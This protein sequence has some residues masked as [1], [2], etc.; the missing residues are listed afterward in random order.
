M[1]KAEYGIENRI[2][3]A[4]EMLFLRSGFAKTSMRDI[5]AYSGVG[6]GNIYNYFKNKDDIFFHLVEPV[7][8]KF[9]TLLEE[10][11]GKNFDIS[12]L[13]MMEEEY[14]EKNL[15]DYT[16]LLDGN[17][18]RMQLL[19]FKAEGSAMQNFKERYTEKATELV[20]TWFM[21]IKKSYPNI[22]VN[23]SKFSVHLHTVWMLS[24]IENIII[25]ND[26]K[27]E[28]DKLIKEYMLFETTGWRELMK[29]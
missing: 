15:R 5:A 29:I 3:E 28:V 24:F 27:E 17:I 19:F 7:V 1:R 6:L 25:H 23:I 14:M 11:H 18:K 22:N 16:S 10:H 13:E 20:M 8:T 4:S 9:Y 12:V 26:K 21:R 2:L